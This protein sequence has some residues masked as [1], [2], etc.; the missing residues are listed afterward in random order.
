MFLY[1]H[2]SKRE[3]FSLRK[4][5][6][7]EYKIITSAFLDREIDK[8]HL[9]VITCIDSEHPRHTSHAKFLVKVLDINDNSPK[10]KLP[11]YNISIPENNKPFQ[12]SSKNIFKC[13]TNL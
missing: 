7:D 10:F 12:V 5:S 1:F 9:L 13:F 2:Q 11:L 3:P 6:L 8:E 4:E